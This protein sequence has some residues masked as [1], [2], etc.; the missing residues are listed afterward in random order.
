MIMVLKAN[1]YFRLQYV[2]EPKKAL[3][4]LTGARNSEGI[5]SWV[6]IASRNSLKFKCTVRE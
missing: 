5:V 2:Q 4:C 3:I 6:T 1:L